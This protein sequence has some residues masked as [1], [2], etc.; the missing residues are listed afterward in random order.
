MRFF[1]IITSVMPFLTIDI[2]DRCFLQ[3]T[4]KQRGAINVRQIFN[5]GV[6][7]CTKTIE[8]EEFTTLRS[9]Y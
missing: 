8:N 4:V 6:L 3:K 2:Y 9:G 5:F 7:Y 1:G